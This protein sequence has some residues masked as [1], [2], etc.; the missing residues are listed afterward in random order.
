MNNP[1]IIK[2]GIERRRARERGE[3]QRYKNRGF[4]GFKEFVQGGQGG[5]MWGKGHGGKGQSL[6]LSSLC[7]KLQCLLAHRGMRSCACGEDVYEG[8]VPGLEDV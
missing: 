6:Y 5:G 1:D 3:G 8:L 4:G 7:L 2:R